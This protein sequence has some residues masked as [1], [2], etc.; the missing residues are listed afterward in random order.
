M[1]IGLKARLRLI[2][3][4]PIFMLIGIASYYV[5]DS[6]V[7]YDSAIKLQSKLTE[8]KK[9]NELIGDLSRERGMTVMF[10]GNS[11]DAT[12]ESLKSQRIVVD[13]K[14]SAYVQH[15]KSTP[16]LH[17][18]TGDGQCFACRSVKNIEANYSTIREVRPLVDSQNVEFQE[19]FYDIYGNAQKLI[20]KELEEI[21][22]Y[23]LDEKI[24][25]IATT[26]LI[27]D[28]SK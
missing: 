16:A 25:S 17:N 26:Y 22:N 19:I 27:I 15:L 5:Y 6:Y 21:I 10:M 12:A 9:L 1:Q 2:S 13:K 23:K 18:H 3:L 7:G 11:S 14:V 4:F 20:I 8:N 24:T 28:N